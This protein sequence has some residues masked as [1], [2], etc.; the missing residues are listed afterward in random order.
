MSKNSKLI[1]DWDTLPSY[2]YDSDAKFDK[3]GSQNLSFKTST[4]KLVFT[5]LW[6][7]QL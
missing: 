1:K 4:P 6:C 3:L 5:C 2:S 7:K